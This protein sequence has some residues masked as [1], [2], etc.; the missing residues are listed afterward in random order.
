MERARIFEE[1]YRFY[2]AS[3]AQLDLAE[4]ADNLGAK[5]SGDRLCLP[6]Y[7]KH[8]CISASGIS[9]EHNEH[10]HF[11]VKVVVCRYVI[12]CPDSIAKEE[13][14]QVNYRDFRDA[15]PLIH[16]FTSNAIQPIEKEFSGKLSTLHEKC[17]RLGGTEEVTEGYDLAMRF[18]ALPRIPVY[19]YFNDVDDE[20][21]AKCSILFQAN[22]KHYL[23]MECLAITGTHL[24][25]RLVKA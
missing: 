10:V 7:D 12:M 22:A 14:Y 11:P 23:D 24:A 15:A 5:V 16:Y 1:T 4:R 9:A 13:K 8:V 19:L 25:N 17:L 21:P 6:F 2:L 3:L 18:F 20:F